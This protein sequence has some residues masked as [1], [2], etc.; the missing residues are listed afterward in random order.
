MANQQ[1]QVKQWMRI[2]LK[3]AGIY[4]LLFGAFVIIFPNTLFQ[5][6]EMEAPLYPMIWQCVGMIVGVYGLGYWWAARQPFVH[7]PII[8]VGL[9][10]KI[11]GPI[12]MIG[13][14]L[15]GELPLQFGILNIFNDLIWWVPFTV[16][17]YEAFKYHN[18]S[19]LTEN[20]LSFS[21]TLH[22][23]TL[24]PSSETLLDASYRSPVML[25]FLRHFGCTFCRETSKAVAMQKK[26]IESNGTRIVLV[27]MS[28]DA[29]AREFLKGYGME[30]IDTILDP[31]CALYHKFG[32]E[33]GRFRQLF[34]LQVWLKGLKAGVL[35][36][37]GIGPIQGDGFQMPGIFLLHKA[38]I[39]KAYRHSF[40]SDNP[41]YQDLSTCPA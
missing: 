6:L 29:A 39:I 33:K 25:V 22:S 23:F 9:L 15:A 38:Q 28:N 34:G 21:E 20:G 4:N 40:A 7:W 27:H 35:G 3:I 1:V 11:L 26:E 30:D 2:T 18:S 31:E 17:L 14:L 12:G 32:L 5:W 41:D 10:G 8:L 37:H 16:M 19:Q 24:N 13:Y 36:G